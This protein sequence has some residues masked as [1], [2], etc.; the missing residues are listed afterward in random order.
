MFDGVQRLSEAFIALYTAGNP[1]FQNWE[2]QISCC[3]NSQEPSI[4][5]DFNLD[6]IVSVV[7]KGSVDT[8]LPELCRKMEKGLTDWTSF[9][10]DQR[11]RHYYLN[12]YTAE[13]I[14]YL[15]SKL[16]QHNVTQIDDQVLMMLSFVKANCTALDLRRVRHTL[17]YELLTKPEEAIDVDHQAVVAPGSDLDQDMSS[18]WDSCSDFEDSAVQKFDSI[19]DAYMAD[20]RNYLPHILDIN[21]L[22]RLLELLA[23]K[24]S[25]GDGNLGI[26]KRQLPRGLA[27]GNPNLIVCPH[28]DVLTAC[29]SIYM[30]S[31]DQ[32]LP[33]YDEVL[34]C[35]PSTPYEQVEIFLRRCLS[36]GH[37]EQK[38]YSL[39]YGDL[40]TYDVSSKVEDFFQRAKMQSRKD[41]KLV[42]ICSSE[43][44]YAYVPSAFSQYRVHVIP[45]ES[46]ARL[47]HYLHRHFVVPEGRCSAA[48]EFKDRLCVGV[49]SSKRAGVGACTLP[50]L[51]VVRLGIC[52]QLNISPPHLL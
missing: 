38:I 51:T 2:A 46:L 43:R 1:L 10:R 31:E 6:N 42:I 34:L 30:S 23:N 11:S 27:P 37:K 16:T 28:S 33:T 5:M 49:V 8:L 41:Y 17:Q 7:S 15:C 29:I 52:T 26:I 50:M 32:P 13:Q 40:L 48:A 19:W 36:T 24:A 21:S 12:C 3:S 39:L 35:N 14:I 47:Q 44:E 20:M 25:A 9:V 45:Q 22:G 18:E 4:V